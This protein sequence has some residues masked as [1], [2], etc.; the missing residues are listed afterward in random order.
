MRMAFP[1]KTDGEIERIVREMFLHFGRVTAD[2]MRTP[3]RTREEVL[4]AEVTG[5]ERLDQA[6]AEGHGVMIITGHFGNWERLAQWLSESGYTLSVVARDANDNAMNDK[7]AKLR[8]A[9]GVQVLSR[10]NAARM[11]LTRL[12]KGELVG[13]LPDQ[14]SEDE[15]IP[16]FGKP[17][18]TVLGPAAIHERTKAPMLPVFCARIGPNRYRVEIGEP[19]IPSPGLP[20]MQ[21]L[22]RSVNASL[23][24]VIRRYPEQWLWMHDRWKSARKAGLL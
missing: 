13:I 8:E 4:Q 5:K 19:L 20:S 21:G 10:G 2:F 14:N 12:K 23:E 17:C 24:E 7:V 6:L 16:F 11:I 18:G 1:E 15:Y 3:R 22:M 9:A